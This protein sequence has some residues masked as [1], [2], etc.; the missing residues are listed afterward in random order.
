M[1]QGDIHHFRFLIFIAQQRGI[2]MTES[3]R[4]KYSNIYD[5]LQRQFMHNATLIE[6]TEDVNIKQERIRST[7]DLA[8]ILMYLSS[9]LNP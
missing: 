1:L 4:E 7:A 5:Q 6:Q 9:V 3:D 2:T 8:Q